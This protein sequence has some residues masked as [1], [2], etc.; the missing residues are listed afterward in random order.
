MISKSEDCS[1][2]LTSRRLLSSSSATRILFFGIGPLSSTHAHQRATGESK[3]TR[4]K[5][6]HYSGCR[7]CA[8]T[9]KVAAPMQK[10]EF[11]PKRAILRPSHPVTRTSRGGRVTRRWWP[12][13]DLPLPWAA[14][15][16]QQGRRGI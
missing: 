12:W 5:E 8:R 9:S 4:A 16:A 3:Q 7:G 10:R 13:A 2:V 15:G 14:L 6:S 11:D 1:V